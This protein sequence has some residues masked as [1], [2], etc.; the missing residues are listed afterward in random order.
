MKSN[1][2]FS[3][4][5]VALLGLSTTGCVKD[6]CTQEVHYVVSTPVYKT[7]EEMRAGIEILAPQ[8]LEQPGK[9]YF[10][11]DFVLI[12]EL[13][14]GIHIID[15]SDPSNPVQMGFLSIG[16]NVDMA[17]K[18][19]LLYADNYLDLL[20]IDISDPLSPDL[21][22]RT[23]FMF[24]AQHHDPS[25]E[26]YLVYYDQH[27]ET[28]VTPC[29]QPV[30]NDIFFRDDVIFAPTAEAS[31]DFNS[32]SS[33]NGGT[34][35]GGSM[36]RFTLS[37]GHLYTVDQSQLH[38]FD[39]ND[40]TN[41]NEVNTIHAGWGIETIFPHQDR[42]F[43]G[44]NSGMFIFDAEDPSNPQQASFLSHFQACDPVFVKDNYAYVTLRDGTFCQGFDNQ[45][46]LVDITDIYN[47]VLEK[48]FPMDNP[49][50]LSI[51]GNTLFLCEGK[52]GLKVFDIE[53]PKK[54]NNNKLEHHKNMHA[55]DVISVPSQEGLLLLIGDD[56][57]FQYDATNPK[58]LKLLSKITVQ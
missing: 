51:D 39:L 26:K 28:E 43:L 13:R 53:N 21:L 58:N 2:L 49:H 12:N 16:G 52:Y 38:V 17:V 23:E 35:V 14:K 37:Q 55:Y 6:E 20:T 9:L 24:P 25:T 22:S 41:P 1:I 3:L 29:S 31:F 46:D 54:L 40:P 18:D 47:P 56:G 48:T 33:S 50:G 45:L 11:N 8:P 19:D 7:L 57:F 5:A 44:S 4:L 27:I 10:Y 30:P 34:G 42:L 36:A 15:N 32:S